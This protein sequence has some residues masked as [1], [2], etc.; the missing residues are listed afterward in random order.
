[1][2]VCPKCGYTDSAC[3]RVGSH[4]LYCGMEICRLDELENWEPENAEILKD[5]KTVKIDK[6]G[7]R[8]MI[9]GHYAYKLTSKGWVYRQDIQ[10]WKVAPF[11]KTDAEKVLKP[12]PRSQTKLIEAKQP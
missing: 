2:R 7:N 8:M 12:L 10:L 5:D 9:R 3:W 1:M 11:S 4:M 6:R